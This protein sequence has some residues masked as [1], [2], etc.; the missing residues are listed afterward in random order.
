MQAR[1]LN[2]GSGSDIKQGWINLN[3]VQLPGVDAVHNI[4]DLPL[5]FADNSFDEILAQDI[6]EHVDYIPVLKDLHRILA[7]GGRLRIRVP[8]YTS[9]NNYTDPTHK[10]RFSVS[11]FDY[12]AKGTY[13]W[14]HRRNEFYVDFVFERIENLRLNFDKKSSRL[15]VYNYFFEWLFN[16]TPRQRVFYELTGLSWLFPASDITVEL[17]K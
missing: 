13:I 5:P 12:F 11:T 7:P 17:V 1:K 8:H 16:L 4:E 15:L 6:L 10:K 2:L 9:R 14:E 3:I